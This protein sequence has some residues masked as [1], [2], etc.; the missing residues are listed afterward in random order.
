MADEEED[1]D[2]EKLLQ[3][4]KPTHAANPTHTKNSL[5]KPLCTSCRQLIVCRK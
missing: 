2:A 4:M 3:A 5:E 1:K